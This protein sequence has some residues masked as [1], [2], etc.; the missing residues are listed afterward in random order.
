MFPLTVPDTIFIMAASFFIMGLIILAAGIFVL[1]SKV[2]GDDIR[3]IAT[4]TTRLA[5]K[6]ITD[7]VSGLVGN[8]S[9]LVESLNQLVKT[10]AGVGVFLI[11]ISFILFA[12]SFGLISQY[13]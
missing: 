4:Q 1:I 10:T 6:G 11:I 3:T 5:Q 7:E 12:A 13:R 9:A 2:M 8:A